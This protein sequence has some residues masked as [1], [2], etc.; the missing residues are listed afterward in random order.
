M[1]IGI[2][3]RILERKMT[4]IGRSL[5][6][7]LDVLPSYDKKNKYYLFS[8]DKI[9]LHKDFYKNVTTGRSFI[10]QKFYAP[11]WL[12]F[13]LPKFLK[14]NK[15][16][17]FF[18]A[19]QI[20]PLY[21][22]KGIKYILTLNDVIYKVDKSFHPLIYRLYLSFFAYFSVINSHSIVTISEYSKKD[23]LRY[24]NVNEEKIKVIYLAAEK[25]FKQ[26]DFN[27]SQKQDIRKKYNLPENIVLY[28]GVIENRKNIKGILKTADIISNTNIKLNFLLVGRIGYG[29][30]E[31][32]DEIQKRENVSYME[33]I[34]DDLLSIIYNV[35]FAFIFPSYYEGFGYPPLEAMQTGLPVLTSNTTSLVEIVEDGGITLD[36]DDSQAFANQLALLF[37][38][39]EYYEEFKNK[40]IKQA[41]KFNIES[42][43]TK[44][45]E[46]FNSFRE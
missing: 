13:V 26:M 5:Y 25:K 14:K 34:P 17:V 4:G 8:Y 46:I 16:D 35:S 22:I 19:N 43:T 1:N 9:D 18:S 44:L 42:T 27:E 30:N 7:F 3:A 28:L 6:T 29:G 31:L 37:E 10:N 45:V 38:N 23:I 11:F 33:H 40:G 20:L 32:I 36:P 2:D 39:K 15:I 24:Y 21:R 12:N 41:S